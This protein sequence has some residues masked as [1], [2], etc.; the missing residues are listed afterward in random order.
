MSSMHRAVAAAALITSIGV[1]GIAGTAQ[2]GPCEARSTWAAFAPWGDEN[3]YFLADGGDFERGATPWTTWGPARPT[4][5]QNPFGL[6]GPGS[7]S[8]RMPAW[9]GVRSPAICVFD[10]EESL[11][12]A[13][14]AP[15]AGATLEVHVE[16]ANDQGVAA[17]TT[18][19]TAA[20]R[21]WDVTPTI[22]L[23]NLRDANGQQWITIRLTP[24]DGVGSWQVDD[25]MIDPWV[26]R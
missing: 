10:N 14:R 11:R 16:V 12:F 17:T 24:L 20:G 8:M 1:V 18:Y 2:A 9:S 22:A 6:A 15:F 23:P 26:A 19:V 21:R 13:Y 7:R 5:G 25:V 3:Q 4:F